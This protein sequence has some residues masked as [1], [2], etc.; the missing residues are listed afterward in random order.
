[1]FEDIIKNRGRDI[2][3]KKV[4]GSLKKEEDWMNTARI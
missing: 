1:L 4:E 2:I 3:M